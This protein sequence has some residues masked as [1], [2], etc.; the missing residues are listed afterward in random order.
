MGDSLPRGGGRMDSFGKVTSMLQMA[1]SGGAVTPGASLRSM[2]RNKMSRRHPDFNH[3]HPLSLAPPDSSRLRLPLH[4][5]D[6]A[7]AGEGGFRT[8]GGERGLRGRVG[9]GGAPFSN[10]RKRSRDEDSR[11]SLASEPGSVNARASQ[12]LGSPSQRSRSSYGYNLQA[13]PRRITCPTHLALTPT[14]LTRS[15]H[16]RVKHAR[17]TTRLTPTGRLACSLARIPAYPR[18]CSLLTEWVYSHRTVAA[19]TRHVRSSSRSCSSG[20]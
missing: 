16:F 5:E 3:P 12:A 2:A 18:R 17:P 20:C 8:R 15:R 14:H 1:G 9:E 19:L 6:R 13:R 7:R 11:H 10:P 4:R